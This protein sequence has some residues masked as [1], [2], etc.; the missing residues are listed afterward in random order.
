MARP[1]GR[2]DDQG[3]RTVKL[4]AVPAGGGPTGGRT[5]EER[6]K[7]PIVRTSTWATRGKGEGIERVARRARRQTTTPFDASGHRK[8]VMLETLSNQVNIIVEN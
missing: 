8:H 6:E 2:T 3:V 7:I 5:E 1:M 4:P